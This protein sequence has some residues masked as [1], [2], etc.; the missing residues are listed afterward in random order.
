M[1]RSSSPS[2]LLSKH[3]PRRGLGRDQSAGSALRFSPVKV[4][5]Q[6][7]HVRTSRDRSLLREA[8]AHELTCRGDDVRISSRCPQCGSHDHGVPRVEWVSVDAERQL[9]EAVAVPVVSLSRCEDLTA[10]ALT[11]TGRVGVDIESIARVASI[12]IDAVAFHPREQLILD[13][14]DPAEASL[15]RTILWTAKEAILKASG[16]GLA[17]APELLECEIY[18]SQVA[19]IS[20]PKALG[21]EVPPVVTTFRVSEQHV[22]AVAH[23]DD[24]PVTF[25]WW[26]IGEESP[27]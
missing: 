5:V 11:T 13:H 7:T 17:V 3:S 16:T 14:G 26:P 1:W 22:C 20:W 23:A 25:S 6:R 21:F 18:G 9:S 4:F 15:R 24:V 8:A 27:A 2:S 10:V 12:D 19:L